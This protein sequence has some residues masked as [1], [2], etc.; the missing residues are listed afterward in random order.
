[1]CIAGESGVGR[2]EVT[3]CRHIDREDGG[4]GD[5]TH[6]RPTWLISGVDTLVRDMGENRQQR[7]RDESD[8]DCCIGQVFCV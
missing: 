2:R 6:G 1:M 5:T 7:E 3:N 4:R 8:Y